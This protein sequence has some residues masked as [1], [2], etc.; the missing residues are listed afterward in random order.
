MQKDQSATDT[1]ETL[2]LTEHIE[3]GNDGLARKLARVDEKLFLDVVSYAGYLTV[4]PEYNSNLFFWF[5]PAAGT[6]H[7]YEQDASEDD[8]ADADGDEYDNDDS[9]RKKNKVPGPIDW[10][11]ENKPVVLWLQGGPGSSSLFGLF[12]EN[13]PFFVNDDKIS[14]RSKQ[15]SS[16]LNTQHQHADVLHLQ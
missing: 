11:N 16:L 1:S 2:I 15:K 3:N 10:E 14:I 5:F 9:R 7:F 13:G 6:E 8:A 4:N 12:T